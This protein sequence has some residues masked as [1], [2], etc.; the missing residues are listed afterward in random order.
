[1]LKLKEM[2]SDWKYLKFCMYVVLTSALLYVGYLLI[3]NMDLIL[4]YASSILR[5]LSTAFSPLIIGLIIAYLLSPLVEFINNKAVSKFF[6]RLPSDPVK[7]EKILRLRRTISILITFILIFI[8]IFVIIYAFAFLIIGDLAFSSLQNMVD[9]IID[10]F[11]R[12]ESVL[13]GWAAAIPNSGIEERIQNIANEIIVWISNHLSTS[14][15]IN[16]VTNLGGS[17]LSIVLGIVVS[18]YF[19]KDKDFFLRLWRKTLHVILPM[20]ANTMVSETL[21]DINRVV[22]QFLRGQMLDALLIAILSSIAFSI[23]DLEFAVFLGCFAGI[24]NI[25]PYFGPII[26][27]IPAALVGL[28]TEGFSQAFFAALAMIIVQQIDS[29]ILY[30]RIVGSTVGLHPLFILISVTVGGYYAGIPGMILA[31]PIAGII[32]VLLMKKLDLLN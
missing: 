22:S 7:L 31:V 27:T 30:P 3:G 20:K 10:Y 21:R 12:Y 8:I 16:F 11:T 14:A 15:I 2:L 9:T 25:I 17:I 18:I 28:I 23:I 13:R 1:M 4:R 32:K 29:N 26:S 19:L 24:C 5:S 6:F